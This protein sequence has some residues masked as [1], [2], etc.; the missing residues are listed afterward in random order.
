MLTEYRL[1]TVGG[2]KPN[3]VGLFL[4][5]Y[6]DCGSGGLLS[7]GEVWQPTLPDCE[8]IC[9]DAPFPLEA[10]PPDYQGRQWFSLMDRSADAI[11]RGV[12]HAAPILNEYI[13]HVLETRGIT[14]DRLVLIGFSQGTMMSLY[15]GPR[16]DKPVAGII[17][18]SG[19]LV[20]GD[21]L[22][23]QKKS[24]MPVLL[25]HGTADDIV[26]YPALADAERGLRA[27]EIPV[28]SVTCPGLGHSIDDRGLIEGL[29]FIR[30]ILG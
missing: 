23:V 16:R 17:G 25:V 5:G 29:A 9:P 27:A 21:L 2:R 1:P 8:F 11:S 20:D 19:K 3:A 10:A 6:G 12:R 22:P 30:K 26:P 24:T 13:D 7:I 28:T 14:P 18:Y 15:V 4:H